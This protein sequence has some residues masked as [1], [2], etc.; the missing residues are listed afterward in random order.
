MTETEHLDETEH[1]VN[2]LKII[3]NTI[4][5]DEWELVSGSVNQ[6]NDL[7]DGD[8]V[9]CGDHVYFKKPVMR[10]IHY[11]LKFDLRPVR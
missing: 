7:F 3:I 8:W 11:K 10:G 1:L 5:S 6:D 2:I 9:I 4:E